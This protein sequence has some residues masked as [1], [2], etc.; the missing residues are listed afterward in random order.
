MSGKNNNKKHLTRE[1]VNL[2]QGRLKMLG[3]DS[4][5]LARLLGIPQP[6]IVSNINGHRRNPDVRRAIARVLGEPVEQL[7]PAGETARE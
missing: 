3:H 2:L 5:T 7:F 4:G 6:T 1:Q